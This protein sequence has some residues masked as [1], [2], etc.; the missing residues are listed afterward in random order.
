MGKQGRRTPEPVRNFVIATKR[1]S[2]W[3]SHGQI[4]D[5]IENAFGTSAHVDKSTVGRILKQ[6][7]LTG[8]GQ[9]APAVHGGATSEPTQSVSRWE[10]IAPA[11]WWPPWDKVPS[12]LYVG[13]T[14]RVTWIEERLFEW[15]TRPHPASGIVRAYV[16]SPAD[17][18]NPEERAEL[19]D[20]ESDLRRLSEDWVETMLEYLELARFLRTDPG[21]ASF[22]KH[23][24]ELRRL[25]TQLHS[26]RGKFQELLSTGPAAK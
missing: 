23:A 19:G 18:F 8:R 1:A 6:A 17:L 20:A 10:R 3:L 16:P 11:L 15:I 2:E 21:G 12:D 13:E 25:E 14:P 5:R 9:F 24:P 4:A 7:G 22:G 26:L